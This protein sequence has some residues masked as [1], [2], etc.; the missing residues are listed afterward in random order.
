[1]RAE[2]VI[3]TITAAIEPLPEISGLFL[4]GSFGNG[5]ADDWSDI[6]F[7][8]V[9]AAGA[10]DQI[11]AH[12]K[13]AVALTGPIVLWRDRTV[14][15]TL[16]N[17]ITADYTRIDVLMLTPEQL[18]GQFQDSLRPLIDRDALYDMLPSTS[19]VAASNARRLSYQ[20]DEF[21][22][23]LGLLPLA[24][25]REEYI[26]GV[27]GLFH[28]RTVLTEILIEETAALHRGGALHLNRLL[29]QEQQALMLSLPPPI[30]ERAPLIAAYL[31]YAEAFLPSA[32]RLAKREGIAW[33]D[34]FEQ[35]TWAYLNETLGITAR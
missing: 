23:I 4:S 28:L 16:I 8:L 33:P 1:M 2:H 34:P 12:W 24:I 30:P 26:N 3:E 5:L 22:R 13:H 7:I 11:A 27:A 35:A 10:T 19:P 9:S 25:G 29:T 31:A 15:P 20:I 21:F 6:D 32:R 14:R 17:A 18:A